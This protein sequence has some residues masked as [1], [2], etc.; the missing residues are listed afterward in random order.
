MK[1][2]RGFTLIELV[3]VI[4]ILGILAAVAIPKF[5]DMSLD[6]HNAAA[7]G[8]AGALSSGSAI[9]YAGRAIG[10]AG[11]TVVSAASIC[12]PT[13][14]GGLLTGGATGTVNLVTTAPA[15]DVTFQVGGTVDCSGA[16]V[17]GICTVTSRGTGA[18]AASA[19]ILCAR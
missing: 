11:A 7:K 4:I 1:H 13:I 19:V 5:I 12:T 6:A 10:N 14:L 18:A 15:D 8:V 17:S 3:V 16:A 2:Q 9:N